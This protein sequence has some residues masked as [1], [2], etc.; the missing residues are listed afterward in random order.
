MLC[1]IIIN[2]KDMDDRAYKCRWG[3]LSNRILPIK[4]TF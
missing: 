2:D 1:G 3:R 4:V